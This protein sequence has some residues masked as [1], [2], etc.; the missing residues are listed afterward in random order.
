M[1]RFHKVANWCDGQSPEAIIMMAYVI[2]LGTK[3]TL[4]DINYVV[5]FFFFIRWCYILQSLFM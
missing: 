3:V 1:N 4:H 2:F 5:G